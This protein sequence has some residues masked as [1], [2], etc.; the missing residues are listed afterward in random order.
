MHY[1][2]IWRAREGLTFLR[3]GA[4]LERDPA[5]TR[6]AGSER[7]P[8]PRLPQQSYFPRRDPIVSDQ[9]SDVKAARQVAVTEF[10]TIRTGV[11]PAGGQARDG[12]GVR[13]RDGAAVDRGGVFPFVVAWL[14]QALA[15]A[16]EGRDLVERGVPLR[17]VPGRLGVRMFE[18]RIAAIEGAECAFATASGMAATMTAMLTLLEAGDHIVAAKALFGSC[19]Y[20]VQDLLPK[21][22]VQSTLVDGRDLI[23]RSR[24]AFQVTQRYGYRQPFQTAVRTVGH[25]YFPAYVET[26][27]KGFLSLACG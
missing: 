25:G 1:S 10:K 22:G 3:G 14:H 27:R 19:L 12:G 18:D 20:V 11:M 7:L 23:C 15:K 26:A 6:I 8:A 9:T 13:G 5:I 17:D 24:F 2:S 21:F 16:W 4:S